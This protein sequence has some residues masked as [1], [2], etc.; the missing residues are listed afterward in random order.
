MRIISG[1]GGGACELF[2]DGGLARANYFLTE[3]GWRVRI[4]SGQG[5]GACELFQDRGVARANYF[6]TGGW[7]VRIIS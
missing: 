3:G 7:R 6:L 1:Q 2:L 4:I 5:A